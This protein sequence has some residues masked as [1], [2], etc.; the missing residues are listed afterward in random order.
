MLEIDVSF[1]LLVFVE[2][3]FMR[4][5]SISSRMRSSSKNCSSGLSLQISMNVDPYI[6]KLFKILP[7]TFN[8]FEFLL[9][10]KLAA[11]TAKESI[12]NVYA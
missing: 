5:E 6:F 11:F 10:R 9:S 8:C 1:D 12:Y 4:F 3:V 2:V 7:N